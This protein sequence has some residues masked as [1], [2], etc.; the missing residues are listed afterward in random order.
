M[1]I[2]VNLILNTSTY[3]YSFIIKSCSIHIGYTDACEVIPLFTNQFRME[4]KD[5]NKGVLV[6][7]MWYNISCKE[8]QGSKIW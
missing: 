5:N 3:D 4:T 2:M 7:K 6:S 1:C 8:P